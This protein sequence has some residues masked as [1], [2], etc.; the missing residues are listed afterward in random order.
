MIQKARPQL[1]GKITK[2]LQQ[3]NIEQCHQYQEI[4]FDNTNNMP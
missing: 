2:K 1:A 3:Y 4:F